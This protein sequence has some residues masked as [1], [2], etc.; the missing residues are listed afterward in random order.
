MNPNHSQRIA[1]YVSG[2]MSEGEL[3]AFEADLQRAPELVDEME[4]T[5]RLREGLAVLRDRGQLDGKAQA[6]AIPAWVGLAASVAVAAVGAT[7]FHYSTSI[8]NDFLFTS[9]PTDAQA[10]A[11]ETFTIVQTRGADLQR[12]PEPRPDTLV[13]LLIRPTFPSPSGHY[14]VSLSSSDAGQ[15]SVASLAGVE[16]NP[17]GWVKVFARANALTKGHYALVLTP[18]PTSSVAPASQFDVEIGAAAPAR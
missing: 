7:L 12:L 8:R 17:E 5:L 2:R 16:A 3:Q 10:A 6:R 13:L 11:L 18:T 4:Q 1:N 9:R 14:A 15:H